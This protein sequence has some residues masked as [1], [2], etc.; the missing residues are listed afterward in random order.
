MHDLTEAGAAA[1]SFRTIDANDV[2]FTEPPV[3]AEPRPQIAQQSAPDQGL[4]SSATVSAVDSAF[5]SLAYTVIGQNART[6]EDLVKEMLRP[7]LKSW[8]ETICPHG[9]AHRARRDERARAA[10]VIAAMALRA[11]AHRLA[12]THTAQWRRQK[13]QRP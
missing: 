12:R 11:P 8:L 9:R 2:V 6:L 3:R 7:L 5:N 10:A 4:I 1:P 13:R